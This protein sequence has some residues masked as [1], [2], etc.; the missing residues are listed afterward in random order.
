[1]MIR[2][3][4]SED[5]P[6]LTEIWNDAVHA[7]EVVWFEMSPEYRHTKFEKNPDI[8]RDLILTA[9]V[10]DEIAGFAVG[11]AQKRFLDHETNANTPGYLPCICVAPRFRGRGIG[12]ALTDEMSARLKARG[13]SSVSLSGGPLDLDWHIPGTRSHDHNNVPGV[14][15]ECP[16]YG[17]FRHLGFDL[18][19]VETAMYLDLKDYIPLPDMA[20]RQ[21]KLLSEGIYTGRYDASLDLDYDRACDRVGSDYWRAVIRSELACWKEGRPNTDPRFIP[22]GTRIPAGP[23]PLLT[24]CA[25]GHI[26]AFTGPVDLQDSGRGW[27]TGIFTDPEYRRR[28]IASVL[29]HSLMREFI[30]EGASFS[31]LFTGENNPARQIYLGAGF[32]IVRRFALMSKTL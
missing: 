4:R 31:T 11:I 10:G 29:F 13:K 19:G 21:A 18:P 24:A 7:G 20:E 28:G 23:R 16:G 26:V 27:F 12:R 25:D 2:T 1:M 14:D 30:A 17:F 8:D 9:A 5:L 32:R 22:N 3:V 15:T 6:F